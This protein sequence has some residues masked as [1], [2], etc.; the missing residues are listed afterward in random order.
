MLT[1]VSYHVWRTW[2]NVQII[3]NTLATWVGPGGRDQKQAVKSRKTPENLL[4]VDFFYIFLP[5]RVTDE[6]P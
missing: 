3:K 5:V 4:Q 6:C 2:A 1:M